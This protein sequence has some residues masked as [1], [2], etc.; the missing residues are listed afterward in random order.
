MSLRPALEGDPA[1]G[2]D[3]VYFRDMDSDGMRTAEWTWVRRL[4]GNEH[5]LYDLEADPHQENNLYKL[6]PNHPKAAEMDRRMT[7]AMAGT[8]P[9]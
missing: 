9:A 1:C 6:D 2:K 7:A 5:E 4:N 8:A 3:A